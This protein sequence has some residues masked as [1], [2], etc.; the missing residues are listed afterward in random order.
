MSSLP[1]S[2]SCEQKR[3]LADVLAS[4][5]KESRTAL[6]NGQSVQEAALYL[7]SCNQDPDRLLSE[8]LSLPCKK[9]CRSNGLES[10]TAEQAPAYNS[11]FVASALRD[12]ALHLGLPAG[13]VTARAA[14]SNIQRICQ[15]SADCAHGAVLSQDQMERLTCLLKTLKGLLAENCFCR[16]L[17]SKEFWEQQRHPVLEAVWRL[18]IE[19][20]V[21]LEDMLESCKD[22]TSAVD[23]FCEEMRSLCAHM[24]DSSHSEH[25]QQMASDILIVLVG[26]AFRPSA[27]PAKKSEQQ[28]I[29]EISI[30]ILD[31]M[32]SWLL[33]GVSEENKEEQ[34]HKPCIACHWLIAF[35]VPRYRTRLIPESL[36]RFYVHTLNQ[37]L[38]YKPQLK[39][40]DAIRLQGNW[41]FAKTCPLLTDLYRKLFVVLDAVKSTAHIQLVLETQEV[42]WYHVL[43]CLSCLVICQAEAQQ[44]VKNLLSHLLTQAFTQYEL[45]G[46]ITAFLFAR[47]AALEGPAAFISY[48]EWFKTT[49]GAA[50]S[51]HSSSKKSQVFLLKFLSDLVPFESPQYLKIHILHPPFVQTKYRP[52]LMEYISLAKTRLTDLKVSIED[53]GLYEDLSAEPDKNQPQSQAL[54]DVERAV[55]IFQT[56]SK[57]PA[58]VMEASIFRRSYFTSRFLPALLTPRELPATP[59]YHMLLIDA[60]KR[61]EKIPASLYSTYVEACEQE[62]IRNLEGIKTMM[63]K[64]LEDEPLLRLKSALWDLRPL[65]IDSNRYSD[66]SAQVALISDKLSAVMRTRSMEAAPIALENLIPAPGSVPQYQAVADLLLTCFCHCVMAASRTNPPDRQ[67][68]WP[69]LYTKMLCGHHLALSAIL[70]RLLQLL[71]NQA[72]LLSDTHIVGIA[73][74]AVHLH[75]C[76]TSLPAPNDVHSLDRFW[77]A[78]FNTKCSD[79]ML[80]CLRFCVAAVSY[81]FCRFSMLDPDAVSRCIP[82]LFLQKLQH[83]APRL[84]GEVRGEVIT[85][86]K[87]DISLIWRVL[88]RPS[89]AWKESVLALWHQHHLQELLKQESFRLSFKDWLLWE[90]ALHSAKDALRDTERQDYQRWAINQVYLPESSASGGCDGDLEKACRIIVVAVLDF[91]NRSGLSFQQETLSQSHSRTGLIDILSR[92]QDLVC[93]LV[94]MGQPQ[95][96][97]VSC[98]HFFFQIFHER[99]A[100][101]ND[102]TE[103]GARLTRQGE[104]GMCCRILLGLPTSLLI[105]VRSD[106]GIAALHPEDFFK[107]VNEEWKNLGPRGCALPYNVT[108]H[109]FRAMLTTSSQCED[110][111]SA[112][113]SLLIASLLECP[114]ILTSAALWW[115]QIYPAIRN[116]CERLFGTVLPNEVEVLQEMRTAVESCLSQGLPLRH[117]GSPWLL[118]AF[119]HFTYQRKTFA[120]KT[121]PEY[122]ASVSTKS[123]PFLLSVL[124]FSIMELIPSLLK[125]GAERKIAL[126]NCLQIVRCLEDREDSWIC[127]FQT[128]PG[129]GEPITTLHRTASSD[130]IKL[131]PFAFYSLIPSVQTGKLIKQHN[132]L[133]V[134]IPMYI[135]LV[136]LFLDGSSFAT[137]SLQSACVH[138]HDVIT[139]GR[140]FLL[141]V[142]PKCTK[143]SSALTSQVMKSCDEYDPELAS[144]LN[145]LQVPFDYEDLAMEPDLF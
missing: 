2:T 131:L 19:D 70:S 88:S 116:Q 113:N 133:E 7:L 64:S 52:L 33:D 58:S 42:N 124:F 101:T 27:D 37:V 8:V 20:I 11:V 117:S 103:M 71:C 47:Q 112:V 135:Q 96:G 144:M 62:R 91:S 41:S 132:F 55:Q 84:I 126:E 5:P 9:I 59:D 15:K 130:F 89:A 119:L 24:E 48:T 120:G 65:V 50:S 66:V 82:P 86:A 44:L 134:A 127:V 142:V 98:S 32:L 79:T 115:P 75:D 97:W 123:T 46:L 68:P 39:A 128:A 81:A 106:R 16:S 23:W 40:S 99:L 80:V 28:R 90:M 10:G 17:F 76:R 109:F 92:L 26:N 95:S 118:A 93:D 12:Q 13:I 122:L 110:P 87:M 56:T 61:A 36:V 145:F 60:L 25:L 31:R 30:L 69:S 45:D 136:Q 121:I 67:G 77:E 137:S 105:S 35:D 140:S 54:Q 3:T 141:R 18:H 22:T 104:L 72:A 38:T 139:N 74:F 100:A 4:W 53:M 34:S 73:V 57:I 49:F 108:I 43:T 125:E 14:V 51:C 78:L 6:E 138:Y 143:P 83:L 102:T 21:R 129:N 1:M 114:I 111:A 63:D 94:I 107:F 85:D 29:T